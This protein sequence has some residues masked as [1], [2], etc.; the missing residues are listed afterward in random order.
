[1]EKDGVVRE[2][3]VKEKREDVDGDGG[4]IKTK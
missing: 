1:M 3:D 4:E 2:G